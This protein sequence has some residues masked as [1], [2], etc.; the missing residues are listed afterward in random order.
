MSEEE[1]F[2]RN[3]ECPDC[4]RQ[5]VESDRVGVSK[6]EVTYIDGL[7]LANCKGRVLVLAA[8]GG[9]PV[10]KVKRDAQPDSCEVCVAPTEF[11]S[12]SVR[13]HRDDH[14]CSR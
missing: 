7:D 10:G 14:R 2:E 5:G 4:G 3:L 9:T 8:R 1:P 11:K 6:F 12:E 13:C